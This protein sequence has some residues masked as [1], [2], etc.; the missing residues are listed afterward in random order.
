MKN[1]VGTQ[2]LRK[3]GRTIFPTI[4]TLKL[5]NSVIKLFFHLKLEF[6]KY[7]INI[8]FIRKVEITNKSEYS[9]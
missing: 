5:F 9:R 4:I 2:K 8:G 3:D 6:N 1:T 7:R